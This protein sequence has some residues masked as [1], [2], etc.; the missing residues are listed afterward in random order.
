MCSAVHIQEEF[1]SKPKYTL[2][3]ILSTSLVPKALTGQV[4]GSMHPDPEGHIL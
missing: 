3:L 1:V 4:T 2:G